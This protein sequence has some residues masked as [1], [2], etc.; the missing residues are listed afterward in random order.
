MT[1]LK[2]ELLK[3]QVLKYYS[4]EGTSHQ[5]IVTSTRGHPSPSFC[6][7]SLRQEHRKPASLVV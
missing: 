2:K 3:R 1:Q 7:T 4:P 5:S 6:F